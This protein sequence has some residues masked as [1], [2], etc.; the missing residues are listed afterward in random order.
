MMSHYPFWPRFTLTLLAV[1]LVL[2]A[3]V[4]QLG[5]SRLQAGVLAEEATGATAISP[6]ISYQGRLLNPT[7][8]APLSGTFT[9]VFRIYNV[10]SGGAALWTETKDLTVTNGLFATLLGDTTALPTDIFTGQDLWLGVKVGADAEAAPRQRIAAVAYALYSANADLL[11]GQDSL[12]YRNATNINAGTLADARIPAAI[13]RDSEVMAIVTAAD[14]AVSGLDADLLDGQDSAAFAAASHTHD[15]GAITAGSLAYDR[16]DAYGDLVNDGKIGA[17]AD[18]VAAGLHTHTGADIVDGSIKAVDLADDSVTSAKIADG[19]VALA[20]LAANSVDSA[21]IVDLAVATADLAN[22][23]V[24][25]A[26]IADGAVTAAKLASGVVPKFFTLN[27]FGAFLEGGATFATGWGPYAGMRLPDSGTPNFSFSFVIPPDYT[28]GTNLTVRFIWHTPATSCGIVLAPNYISVARAGR[29]HIAGGGVTDGLT[30]V[31]GNVLSA[32]A[33][34]SQSSAKEMT[35]STPVPGTK[36]QAD[37]SIIFGLYRS[38]GSASDT[39]ANYLVI[40][41]VSV[42][43]Q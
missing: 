6:I 9:F 31:G 22:S 36:L 13:A 25:T 30:M 34:A 27:T 28:P 41:G 26:K 35:I 7:T 16:F 37:D 4:T 39:C 17:A 5:P 12:Y 40:Q 21:R 19:G 8:G 15:A 38:S 18:M 2:G 24:T 32:P 3:A 33:T 20:D 42:S 14:G 11:D 23:S 10:A 1:L 43:Y 29:T